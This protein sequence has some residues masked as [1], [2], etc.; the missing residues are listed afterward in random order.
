MDN[1]ASGA[2]GQLVLN[3]AMGVHR[4]E[5]A[6]V[7]APPQVTTER[8]ALEAVSTQQSATRLAVEVR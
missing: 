1:G 2:R 4:Q 7:I 5:N 8:H 6:L 3:P